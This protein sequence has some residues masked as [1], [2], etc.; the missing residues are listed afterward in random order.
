[1]KPNKN[2]SS[3]LPSIITRR[4]LNAA[5]A[6]SKFTSKRLR[7]NFVLLLFV[8]G[9]TDRSHKAVLRVLELCDTTLKGC[10]KL[11]VIDIFQQPD[12]AREYQIIATPTLIIQLP[13]PVRRFIGNL[14]NITNLVSQLDLGEKGRISA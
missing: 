7:N 5:K 6:S 4:K 12:L 13:L 14:T 8:A 9:A 11:E 3:R 1:M 10:A 2:S